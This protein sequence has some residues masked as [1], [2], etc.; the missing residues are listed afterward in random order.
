MG[1]LTGIRAWCEN[2]KKLTVTIVGALVDLVPDKY[3]PQDQKLA[4][5]ATLMAFILGQGIA[6]HGKEAAKIQAAAACAQLAAVPE[7]IVTPGK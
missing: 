2:H 1:F 3:L 6:D 5:T 7:P 4:M